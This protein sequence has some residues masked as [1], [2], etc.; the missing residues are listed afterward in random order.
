MGIEKDS[1][2]PRWIR[3]KLYRVS[4]LPRGAMNAEGFPPLLFLGAVFAIAIEFQLVVDHV[5]SALFLNL[6]LHIGKK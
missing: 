5:K 4:V 1:P 3:K 2:L 6:V